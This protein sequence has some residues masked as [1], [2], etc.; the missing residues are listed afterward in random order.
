MKVIS[1]CG[2][3][4]DR[5]QNIKPRTEDYWNAYFYVWAVK[6]GKFKKNFYIKTPSRGNITSANFATVR[7]TFG[8][9]AASQLTNLSTEARKLVPVPSKDALAAATTY[10]SFEMVT[11]SF[12]GTSYA[13]S[14]LDGL[15]WTEEAQ[16]AHE[17]GSR[18]RNDLL[19]LLTAA[20]AT[21]GETI[22]LIDEVYSTGGSLLAASDRLVTA[23]ATIAGAITCGKTIYDFNT[24][25]FGTQQFDLTKELSDWTPKLSL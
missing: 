11:E 17:G 21:K 16:K 15:R 4:P 20:T 24:P 12:K 10:R 6:I 25:A 18:K 2:Y 19:P 1:Y 13:S 5:A 7:K 14:V 22:V 3:Y 23:G 8:N 9:W